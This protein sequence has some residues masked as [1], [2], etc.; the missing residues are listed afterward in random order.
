MAVR[1]IRAP[2]T[3][4]T[5]G[6][7]WHEHTIKAGSIIRDRGDKEI[8]NVLMRVFGV[9]SFLG[10][11][12]IK[13]WYDVVRNCGN[14]NHHQRMDG[15]HFMGVFYDT[16]QGVDLVTNFFIRRMDGVYGS[17]DMWKNDIVFPKGV[18][19]YSVCVIL[20]EGY[21]MSDKSIRD[22]HNHA[23]PQYTWEHLTAMGIDV[24]AIIDRMSYEE[25]LV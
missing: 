9:K 12:D 17:F 10:Y 22:P 7:D 5:D 23:V 24:Q 11:P 15:I 16:V 1:S 25:F 14:P 13:C 8:Q 20:P 2:L 4:K 3:V 19:K 18:D 6:E 21:K